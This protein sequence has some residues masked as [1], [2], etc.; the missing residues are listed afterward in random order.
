M[1]G[2]PVAAEREVEPGDRWWKQ[3]LVRV[4]RKTFMETSKANVKKKIM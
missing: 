3:A 1:Y 4:I 2:E